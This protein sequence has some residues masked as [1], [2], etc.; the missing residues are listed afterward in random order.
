MFEAGV[1]EG[2]PGWKAWRETA[3]SSWIW[4]EVYQRLKLVEICSIGT[5]HVSDLQTREKPKQLS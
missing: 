4:L 3:S 2:K 5:Y 1:L